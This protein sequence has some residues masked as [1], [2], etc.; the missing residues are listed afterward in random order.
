[1]LFLRIRILLMCELTQCLMCIPCVSVTSF[2]CGF[3]GV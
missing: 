2:V 3:V 1:M